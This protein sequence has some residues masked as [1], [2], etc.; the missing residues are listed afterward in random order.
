MSVSNTV[1]KQMYNGN[2]STT[3]FAIPFAYIPDEA[4]AQVKV[5]TIV[6]STGVATLR[7]EGAMQDYT[8]TP[9]Y[10]AV[11]NPNGPTTV[12]FNTAPTALQKVLVIRSV[13]LTQ[14]IEYIANASS[15]RADDVEEGMD[16]LALM[17]QQLAEVLGRVPTIEQYPAMVGLFDTALPPDGAADDILTINATNDGFEWKSPAAVA[18]GGG[19]GIP[20]GG[21]AG[22]FLEKASATDGDAV[23][24]TGAYS[25]ISRFG[26]FSST[27]LEDTIAQIL[28][29][30]YTPPSISLAASGSGTVREKGASVAS[31][32]LTATITK[33]SDPIV[34]VRFYQGVTLLDTQTGNPPVPNGGAPTYVYSVAF[35]DNISFSAQTIDDGTSGGPTNVTS[36]T[37][38]FTFVYPYYSG[39]GAAALAAASVGALT[40]D[41][42]I[43]T[44]SLNKSFTPNGSQVL[45]FAYPASYGALTSILDDNDFETLGDW[46]LRTE[47]ITGLDATAQ[48][49]R[50]YEFNNTPVSGTY[51]FTFI[52]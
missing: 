28:N 8:L 51:G 37:V 12:V 13:P 30:T 6:S 26:A 52:R 49:Y 39:V 25:G 24:M 48:S 21:V 44:S 2:G 29:I 22:D 27:G 18:S 17:I 43:S 45:Y 35:T 4:S 14:V 11:T 36:S 41:V 9:A 10:D 40:K 3:N 15:F 23:W 50:I 32:T 19:S 20:V 46:T 7:T 16:R 31:T 1:V 5:Y 38:S 47:N 34:D 42:R 33:Q